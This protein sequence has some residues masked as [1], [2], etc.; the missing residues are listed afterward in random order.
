MS[1]SMKKIGGWGFGLAVAAAL[2][3]GALVAV[4]KPANG[5]CQGV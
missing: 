4:A 1:H 2:A 5:T 3:F